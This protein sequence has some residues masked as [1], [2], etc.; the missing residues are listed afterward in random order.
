MDDCGL[1]DQDGF[2]WT[3]QKTFG[4]HKI[5]G[6]SGVAHELLASQEELCSISQ[7]FYMQSNGSAWESIRR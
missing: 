3:R 6:I 5:L 7:E 1:G 4:L 2:M